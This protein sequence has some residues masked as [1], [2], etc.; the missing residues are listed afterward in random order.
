[1]HLNSKFLTPF[2][3]NARHQPILAPTAL[4]KDPSILALYHSAHDKPSESDL[5]LPFGVCGIK[6]VAQFGIKGYKEL[7]GK[8]SLIFVAVRF[9]CSDPVF[10]VGWL[11]FYILQCR[12][13]VGDWRAVWSVSQNMLCCVVNVP[14]I[15]A[16]Q[17]RASVEN[18]LSSFSPFWWISDG[19]HCITH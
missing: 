17:C 4:K 9:W 12:W 11:K 19:V 18:I 1:M 14:L 13:R 5:F 10:W 15:S 2:C 6:K 3:I 8:P 7:L 16:L